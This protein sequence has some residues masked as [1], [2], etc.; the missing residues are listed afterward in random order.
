MRAS[1]LVDNFLD[2]IQ[3]VALCGHFPSCTNHE[4]ASLC[5]S[6]GG[7]AMADGGKLELGSDGG[8]VANIDGPRG[9]R[10]ASKRTEDVLGEPERSEVGS[11]TC[12]C[13]VA[14][15]V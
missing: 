11:A 1:L 3:K 12:S 2:G 4:H 14:A 5:G 7:V 6:L 15:V 8:M 10:P 13:G 9:R